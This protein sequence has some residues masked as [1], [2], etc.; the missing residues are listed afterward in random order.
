MAD[1]QD[2]WYVCTTPFVSADPDLPF[3]GRKGISRVCGTDPVYLHWPQFFEP[4]TSSD[5]SERPDVEMALAVP[6]RKR[7]A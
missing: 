7:G 5:R 2:T 4:I 1:P 3:S 6:G